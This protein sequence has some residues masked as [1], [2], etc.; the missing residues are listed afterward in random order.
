MSNQENFEILS[1]FAEN[2]PFLKATDAGG[3]KKS[4]RAKIMDVE[5]TL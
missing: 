2:L 1:I 3:L 5:S 4:F